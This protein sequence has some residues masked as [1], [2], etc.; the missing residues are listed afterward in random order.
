M[1]QMRE[2]KSKFHKFTVDIKDYKIIQRLGAGGFSSV[3]SVQNLKTGENMAAKVLNLNNNE[4]KCKQMINREIGIMIRCQHPTIV[5]FIG[6]SIKDFH[7]ENNITILMEYA[8]KGSLS[9]FLQKV[10][11]GLLDETYNNTNRQIILIGIARG[12]MYLHQHQIIH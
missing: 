2:S 5:R 8:A 3:Y 1:K 4:E 11:N 12:M 6:F 10:Q 7:N 9:I